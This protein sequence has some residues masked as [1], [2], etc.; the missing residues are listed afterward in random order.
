MV[1]TGSGGPT[2]ADIRRG[3]EAANSA[4]T[5][6][7]VQSMD[8]L[9]SSSVAQPRFQTILVA[10]FAGIGLTL[11]VIGIYGIVSYS[12]AQRTHEIGVRMAIGAQRFHVLHMVLGEGSR[13][14]VLGIGLGILGALA[15]G[16][17]LMSMLFEIKTTDPGTFIVVSIL[18]AA[19]A[20][21]AS[22]IPARR[23]TKV[24]PIVA[25]RYE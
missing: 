25:L 6:G 8:E 19:V 2:V 21:L 16:R 10:S 11:A 3:I 5:A 24:D 12:V 22:Y 23:A 13:L 15:A 14:V 9:I 18:L 20:L 1:R 7:Q 17:V 4:I